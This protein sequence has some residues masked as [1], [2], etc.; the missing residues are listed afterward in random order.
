MR[1]LKDMATQEDLQ[2]IQRTL[3]AILAQNTLLTDKIEK[4]ELEN[5][6]IKRAAEIAKKRD[7]ERKSRINIKK[8]QWVKLNS[9]MEDLVQR[10]DE[11]KRELVSEEVEKGYFEET[12]E[13]KYSESWENL[14]S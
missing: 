9:E 11:V 4:L 12:A 2:A 1:K 7:E 14:L 8:A 10:M 13:W 6:E 3:K 5:W